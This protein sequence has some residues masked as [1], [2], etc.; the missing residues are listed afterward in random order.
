MDIVAINI[1]FR[2]GHGTST[3]N[4][5]TCILEQ[6][7]TSCSTVTNTP[8]ATNGSHFALKTDKQVQETKTNSV[9]KNTVKHHLGS[10]D[11]EGMESPPAEIS[12]EWPVHFPLAK[13]HN[14]DYW[15]SKFVVEARRSNGEHYPPNTL[16]AT[17][18]GLLRYVQE[19][20]PNINFFQD[21][22][23]ASFQ[24]TLDGD[25][26][27]LYSIGYGVTFRTSRTTNN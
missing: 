27:Q 8:S 23:Y 24:K 25:M 4:K 17:C 26:K 18:C 5:C 11:L 20:R 13:D 19:H 12:S 9:P 14:L 7:S 6:P 3:S 16:H 22:F 21:S 1:I 15:L 10:E 2:P